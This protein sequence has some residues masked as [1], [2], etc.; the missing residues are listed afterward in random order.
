MIPMRLVRRSALAAVRM[1]LVL[2]VLLGV[3]YPLGVTALGAALPDRTQGSLLRHD[4]AVTGS[5]LLAAPVEDPALFHPRPS[6]VDDPGAQSG[7]SN[8]GPRSE[9]QA[10]LVAERRRAV[11][12]EN[13]DARG[14]VPADALTAS[15]SGVDPHISPAYA[16]YQVPR[17]AAETGLSPAEVT[18]LVEEHTDRPVWGVVGQDRVTVTTLNAALADRVA[19]GR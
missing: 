19:R 5:A 14:S 17:V 3:A 13:P 16:A 6:A 7:G 2:T 15:G 4:G 9:D 1:L 18:A 11:Q 10:A 12:Q 8:L